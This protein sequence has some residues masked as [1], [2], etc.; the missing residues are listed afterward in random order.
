MYPIDIGF[1]PDAPTRHAF[2]AQPRQ[3][4]II[5]LQG[6]P[7]FAP[8]QHCAAHALFSPRSL[9]CSVPPFVNPID[10][11]FIP[12]MPRNGD[13]R[14]ISH[15]PAQVICRLVQHRIRSIVEIDYAKLRLVMPDAIEAL[16][17]E[18][19]YGNAFE[20]GRPNRFSS[21][22]IEA[23]RVRL[24][25]IGRQRPNL[26]AAGR[27]YAHRSSRLAKRAENQASGVVGKK[28]IYF[29]RFCPWPSGRGPSRC[30]GN[31]DQMVPKLFSSPRV[32]S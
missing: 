7:R 23:N 28:A 27:G 31:G 24:A 12:R 30:F 19:P 16:S 15:G 25:C 32:A 21:H 26:D 3:G 5:G 9:S 4:L 13:F 6:K 20:C 17:F 14:A 8:M 29:F 1:G 2:L 11:D 18:N 10:P 22:W